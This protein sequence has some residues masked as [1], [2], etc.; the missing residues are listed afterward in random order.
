MLSRTVLVRAIA[1][2]PMK[3]GKGNVDTGYV[4]GYVPPWYANPMDQ[5]LSTG[6]GSGGGGGGGWGS[7]LGAGANW[8]FNRFQG[9][10]AT[11]PRNL[12]TIPQQYPTTPIPPIGR[13]GDWNPW[14]R[15]PL[16][17][18]FEPRFRGR[19]R[20]SKHMNFCNCKALNRAMRRITGFQKCVKKS[21]AFTATH[22]ALP[23]PKRHRKV[24]CKCQ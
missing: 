7:L 14:P 20:R 22:A 16:S 6:G 12:P 1:F 10:P 5:F 24:S 9:V 13:P 2:A 23:G 17:Q 11:I 8:L 3:R 15:G 21:H 18:P 4:P 19:G